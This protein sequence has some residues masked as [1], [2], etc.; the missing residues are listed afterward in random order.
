LAVLAD[1]LSRERATDRQTVP[2]YIDTLTGDRKTVRIRPHTDTVSELY[3]LTAAAFQRPFSTVR[4][5]FA[6]K[7]LVD[8]SAALSAVGIDQ[9]CILQMIILLRGS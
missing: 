7:E 5:I 3:L 8:H 9:E 4:L 1:R 2:V 6:A